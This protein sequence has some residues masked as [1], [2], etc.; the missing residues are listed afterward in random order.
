VLGEIHQLVEKFNARSLHFVDDTFT[1]N[2][3][4][5]RRICK[6]IDDEFPGLRWGCNSRVDTITKELMEVMHQ[7]GCEWIAF[8][9]ETASPTI[10]EYLRKGINHETVK[11]VFKEAR[12]VGVNT[13]AY[14]MLGLPDETKE[15]IQK[16]V[17]FSIKLDPDFLT[18]SMAT[19][20]PGTDLYNDVKSRRLIVDDE[21][22]YTHTSPKF[23]TPV[24]KTENFNPQYL[25]KTVKKAYSRFYLQPL[26]IMRQLNRY[27]RLGFGRLYDDINIMFKMLS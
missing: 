10:M 26:F 7:A 18:F 2:H 15:D 14:F 9:V 3:D 24:I 20:Y 4:R 21:W 6:M 23:N 19:P 5:V 27:C 22:W 11:K 17:D 12:E 8:G 25:K 1:I 13:H 16:T